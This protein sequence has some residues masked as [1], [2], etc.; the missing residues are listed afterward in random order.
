MSAFHHFPVMETLP[1]L[2]RNVRQPTAAVDV[3]FADVAGVVAG[4]G[5]H[6]AECHGVVAEMGVVEEEA[7]RGRPLAGHQR[8]AE[9]RTDRTS[10]DGF[11]EI[12]ALF[13]E[14]IEVRRLDVRV[15]GVA[16]GAGPP[17]VGE[18]EEDVRRAGCFTGAAGRSSD[19]SQPRAVAASGV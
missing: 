15:A 14:L 5:Q 16:G 6:L 13:F 1:V 9:G 19:P 17:L 4:G 18:N 11:G 3:P 7:V 10:R 8:A 12:G 2:R